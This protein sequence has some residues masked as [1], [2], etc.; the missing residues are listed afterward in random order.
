MA[1]IY[2]A[3]SDCRR[4]QMKWT[5]RLALSL[6]LAVILLATGGQAIA[7][8]GLVLDLPTIGA[9]LNRPGFEAA[10]KPAESGNPLPGTTGTAD[11]SLVA[12]PVSIV[13]PPKDVSG[14]LTL[15]R[16]TRVLCA[17]LNQGGHTLAKVA[18]KGFSIVRGDVHELGFAGEHW[19]KNWYA[20]SVTGDSLEDAEAGHPAW[21][22][23]YDDDG[24]LSSCAVQFGSATDP[25]KSVS[26]EERA[27]AVQ[28]IY[29]GLPQAFSAFMIEPRFAGLAPVAPSGLILMAVP[30]GGKWCR[31]STI[32]DFGNG[33]WHLS[34]RIEFGVPPKWE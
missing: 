34:S 11:Y 9:V 17:S 21:D 7:Q 4:H 19:K 15:F 18:P 10:G 16:V 24:N 33:K 12:G 25:D 1:F 20:L 26:D 6:P 31:I 30:C 2:R 28:Y 8:D 22:I 14:L 32:Y 27:N 3:V 13:T 5:A 29:I 23:R